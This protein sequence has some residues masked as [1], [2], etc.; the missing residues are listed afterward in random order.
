VQLAWGVATY[1][2]ADQVTAALAEADHFM[3]EQ[4][5]QRKGE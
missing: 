2:S 3:Y 1:T 4:K 5:R